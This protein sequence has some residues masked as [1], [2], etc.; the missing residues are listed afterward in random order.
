MPVMKQ[1]SRF[2]TLKW[3]YLGLI[4]KTK[5]LS[6]FMAE[7]GNNVSIHPTVLISHPENV[8]IGSHVYINRNTD[9]ISESGKVKIGNFVMIGPRVRI[10]AGSHGYEDWRIPM[11]F[12]KLRGGKVIIEDDV[13]IGG[14][15]TILPDVK[16]GR[17][18]IVGAGAMVTHDVRPYTLVGGVPARF[19]KYRFGKRTRMKAGKL[20]LNRF[21]NQSTL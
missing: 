20:D 10:L 17:G 5:W 9:I 11:Y 3:F 21:L 18:A 2:I 16:I 8:E 4:L 12:Q 19:I 13:W 15:V 14:S 6:F 1:L 7:M